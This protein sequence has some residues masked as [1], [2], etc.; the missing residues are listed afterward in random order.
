MNPLPPQSHK[1]SATSFQHPATRLQAQS[2]LA[3]ELRCTQFS[4]TAPPPDLKPDKPDQRAPLSR[5]LRFRL[6]DL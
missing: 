1:I 6:K 4:G 2:P 5:K 3:C